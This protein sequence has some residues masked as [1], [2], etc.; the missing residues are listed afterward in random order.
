MQ[1]KPSHQNDPVGQTEMIR[2][3]SA[4]PRPVSDGASFDRSAA[5]ERA[6][7]ATQ[8]VR[9]QVVERA[10]QLIEDTSYPPAE[11]INRIANLLGMNLA[12]SPKPGDES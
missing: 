12:R 6:L 11:A 4:T 10:R 9:P 3:Q 2:R 1:V 5:L 8:E 7:A